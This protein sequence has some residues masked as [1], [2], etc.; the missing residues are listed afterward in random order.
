MNASFGEIVNTV[1]ICR[2]V[3]GA[4]PKNSKPTW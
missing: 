3:V 1:W 2:Y 4:D